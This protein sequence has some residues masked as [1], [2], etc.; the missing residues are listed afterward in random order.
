MNISIFKFKNVLHLF[1]KKQILLIFVHMHF[2]LQA[3]C[4]IL[5]YVS[6]D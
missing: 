3:F 2:A 4:K 5:C 6:L 1:F